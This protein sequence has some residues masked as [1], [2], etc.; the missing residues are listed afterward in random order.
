MRDS[1]FGKWN[2]GL[3]G[4]ERFKWQASE[5][6]MLPRMLAAIVCAS[7]AMGA[8]EK[9]LAEPDSI[10]A[11]WLWDLALAHEEYSNRLMDGSAIVWRSFQE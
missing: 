6:P 10:H 2:D 7:W 4:N 1:A 11:E 8:F 5:L 9:A 3:P